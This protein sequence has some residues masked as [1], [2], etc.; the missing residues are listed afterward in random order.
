MF[1]TEEV[2][3]LISVLPFSGIIY[4]YI[5][6]RIYKYAPSRVKKLLKV[7]FLCIK[8]K[9]LY[10]KNI[11]VAIATAISSFKLFEFVC[12]PSS[13]VYGHL[14]RLTVA[15]KLKRYSRC[16]SGGQP[17]VTGTQSC[18]KWGLHGIPCYQGIGEL[19]PRLFILTKQSFAVYFCCTFLKVTFTW[20]YQAL[21]PALLGLS[22]WLFQ[23]PRPY[24]KLKSRVL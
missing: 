7:L 18:S 12:K 19:L 23:A 15:D 22:S 11:A 20:R 14:S 1:V 10:Y 2:A 8:V 6:N 24:N 13:V 21:R 4:S 9:I 17:Y 16:P 5:K 3:N